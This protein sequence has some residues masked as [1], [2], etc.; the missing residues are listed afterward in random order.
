MEHE[1]HSELPADFPDD[2]LLQCFVL[3]GGLPYCQLPKLDVLDRD[4]PVR[5][6]A[7]P[8][9]LGANLSLSTRV[10]AALFIAHAFATL[11]TPGMSKNFEC[12]RRLFTSSYM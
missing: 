8:P 11:L 6:P 9:R 1:R 10:L 12:R 4:G 7:S 3:G 5:T 2:D